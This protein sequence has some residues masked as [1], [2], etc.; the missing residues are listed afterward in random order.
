MFHS[1]NFAVTQFFTIKKCWY[2]LPHTTRSISYSAALN[3]M[4]WFFSCSCLVLHYTLVYLHLFQ[5]QTVMFGWSIIYYHEDILSYANCQ[6][7]FQSLGFPVVLAMLLRNQISF[8]LTQV[9]WR[10]SQHKKSFLALRSI[11]HFNVV[12]KRQLYIYYSTGS[13]VVLMLTC[14]RFDA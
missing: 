6:E 12:V 14:L 11:Y 4:T 7:I 5:S 3:N 2:C 13:T 1:R 9:F 8:L 10:G